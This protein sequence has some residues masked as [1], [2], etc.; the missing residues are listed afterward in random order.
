MPTRHWDRS[1]RE[2]SQGRIIGLLRQGSR[3]IEELSTALGLTGNAVRSH[4]T[5]LERNGFVVPAEQRRTSRKP[6]QA[7]AIRAEAEQRL[8][9]AY[10][11]VLA[12]LLQILARKIDP[13][14]LRSLMREVGEQ[15]ADGLPASKTDRLAGVRAA[16]IILN[17]LGGAVEVEQHNGELR[18]RGD[19]CPLAEAVRVNPE[20]CR[21]V[22][23]LVSRVVGASVT[24]QCDHGDRPRCRFRITNPTPPAQNPSPTDSSSQVE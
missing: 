18:L 20:A 7:Y 3:T 4:I 6:A 24:E 17:D 9:K 10:A 13:A 19:G 23:A 1:F 8:S 12:G 16:A 22:E 14:D 21:A 5:S 15:L 11:P 2:S